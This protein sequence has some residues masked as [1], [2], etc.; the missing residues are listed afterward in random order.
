[1]RLPHST[2]IDLNAQTKLITNLVMITVHS[3]ILIKLGYPLCELNGM[4]YVVVE[5]ALGAKKS[6]C[7]QQD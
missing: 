4:K 6:I 3:G 5:T 2:N 7:P 1:M